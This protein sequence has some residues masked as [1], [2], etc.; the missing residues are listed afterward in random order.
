M[1]A[2]TGDLG[3]AIR[4]LE[5]RLG[6]VWILNPDLIAMILPQTA[7]EIFVSTVESF[8]KYAKIVSLS[9]NFRPQCL[10]QLS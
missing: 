9:F 1:A 3:F 10:L 2:P 5:L 6:I 7:G 4:P 8:Y